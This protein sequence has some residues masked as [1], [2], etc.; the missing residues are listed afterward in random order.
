MCFGSRGRTYTKQ[1]EI[2][3]LRSGLMA[4]CVDMFDPHNVSIIVLAPLMWYLQLSRPESMSSNS[5]K[6]STTARVTSISTEAI[7]LRADFSK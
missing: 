6:R 2:K 4:V 1:F 5:I 3:Q 7:L